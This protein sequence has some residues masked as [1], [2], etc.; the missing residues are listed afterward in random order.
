MTKDRK[1][2]NGWFKVTEKQ[3]CFTITDD[4]L[5]ELL[6]IRQNTDIKISSQIECLLKGYTIRKVSNAY[7][8]KY[9]EHILKDGRYGCS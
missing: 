1:L 4:I 3:I 5:K 7:P 2:K 6:E 8:P 9:H